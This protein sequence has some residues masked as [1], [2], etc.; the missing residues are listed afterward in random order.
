MNANR[1]GSSRAPTLQA[2]LRREARR[3]RLDFS[4]AFHERLMERITHEAAALPKVNEHDLLP[5]P[6]AR[7]PVVFS[8]T[9]AGV[10]AVVAAVWLVAAWLPGRPPTGPSPIERAGNEELAVTGDGEPFS[11][12]EEIPMYDDI[13][14]RVRAGAWMLAASL[15][16]LPDWA[17]LADFDA[18]AILAD[19]SGP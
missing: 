13:D 6:M 2:R 19:A 7:T 18:K 11:G 9:A 12:I 5:S 16:E 15:V 14:A 1:D 4:Q 3:T 17:S 8:G 10:V